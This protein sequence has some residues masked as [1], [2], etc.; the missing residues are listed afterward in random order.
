MIIKLIGMT[1]IMFSSVLLG[2]GFA[3][4]MA[5]RERELDNVADAVAFM[6]GELGYTHLCM[7]DIIMR[8]TP[9]VKGVAGEFFECVCTNIQKGETASYAWENA[10]S[11]KAVAMSLKKEDVEY[12]AGTSHFL[13]AHELDEQIGC[14]KIME[15]RI[16]ELAVRAGDAK[17]K[18]SRM[19]RMLGVYG[20]ILFCI[21]VF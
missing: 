21:L 4:C 1:F 7:R 5:S 16:R 3:E 17:R 9:Y 2:N 8:V 20:G 13:E 18:N 14:L 15:N 10:I 6:A 12:I 19:A 11:E